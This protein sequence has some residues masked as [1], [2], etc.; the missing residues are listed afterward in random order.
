MKLYAFSVLLVGLCRERQCNAVGCQGIENY[1]ILFAR[2]EEAVC[3]N[4]GIPVI[5]DKARS[6]ARRYCA[7]TR[8]HA[9]VTNQKLV[10]ERRLP[11]ITECGCA[12]MS[13]YFVVH[14]LLTLTRV[15][16]VI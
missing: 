7:R 15:V 9:D 16:A 5:P 11:G 1:R 10:Y 12:H 14:W 13:Y 8:T 4:H 6:A 3:L 2:A